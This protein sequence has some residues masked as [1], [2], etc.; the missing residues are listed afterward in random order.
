M[1]F[2]AYRKKNLNI[3]LIT[4]FATIL[5]VIGGYLIYEYVRSGAEDSEHA[6]YNNLCR[7]NDFRFF[8]TILLFPIE[9]TNRANL[10]AAPTLSW[11]DK[12]SLKLTEVRQERVRLE[13]QIEILKETV[14]PA[15]LQ[16]LHDLLITSLISA[17][18]F[19]DAVISDYEAGVDNLHSSPSDS[20]SSDASLIS[21]EDY[22]ISLNR[23]LSLMDVMSEANQ[24]KLLDCLGSAE[25]LTRQQLADYVLINRFSLIIFENANRSSESDQI[26][27]KPIL[28][29]P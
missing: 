20:G 10:L 28:V 23:I 18:N 19:D 29:K 7:E 26:D 25:G 13:K 27:R 24:S 4:F 16:S 2:N 3:V 5:L 8:N 12:I 1:R 11:P 17:F 6:N 21:A 22:F 9:E 14:P 15:D